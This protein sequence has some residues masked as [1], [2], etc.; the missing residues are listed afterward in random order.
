MP[1]IKS[2]KKRVKTAAKRAE[3]NKEWKEK[4]K[5]SIKSFEKLVN[6]GNAA[7]AKEQLQETI[8]VIDKAANRGIIHK[9]N[10]SRKK[11]RLTKMYNKIA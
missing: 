11:A 10:A 5:G 8:K 3:R 7:E 9:N 4:L 6:E 1:I 2:A